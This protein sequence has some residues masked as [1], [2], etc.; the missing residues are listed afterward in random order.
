MH[1]RIPFDEQQVNAWIYLVELPR[2]VGAAVVPVMR[3]PDGRWLQDTGV[4][5]DTLEQCFTHRPVLHV[6][7]GQRAGREFPGR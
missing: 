7:S 2:R 3:T 6:Q 5:I 1:K 4:L